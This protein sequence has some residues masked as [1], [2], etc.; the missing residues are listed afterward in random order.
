MSDGGNRRSG[1]QDA[2]QMEQRLAELGAK[3]DELRERARQKARESG[4]KVSDSYELL[5]KSIEEAAA[6][7]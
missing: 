4:R 7:F 5:R 3:L 2:C 1:P 6:K